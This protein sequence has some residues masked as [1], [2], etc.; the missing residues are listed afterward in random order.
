MSYDPGSGSGDGDLTGRQESRWNAVDDLQES[1]LTSHLLG[2]YLGARL[3]RHGEVPDEPIFN[4]YYCKFAAS[5]PSNVEA[6]WKQRNNDR[7]VGCDGIWVKVESVR[8]GTSD[9][10]EPLIESVDDLAP[11][12]H[13]AAR[14]VRRQLLQREEISNG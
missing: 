14:M 8:G 6:D 10:N 13:E 3:S 4:L 2:N 7:W 9:N 12:P 5:M 1:L 11:S